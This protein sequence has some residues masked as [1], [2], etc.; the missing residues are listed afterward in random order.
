[1]KWHLR[2]LESTSAGLKSSS[3]R[4]AE[5]D[6]SYSSLEFG[7]N[8]ANFGTISSRSQQS[9][10]LDN[11]RRLSNKH[12]QPVQKKYSILIC[13]DFAFPKF[14]GVE[15]HGYQ[16]GQC[17]IERGHKVCFITNKF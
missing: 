8:L 13:T 16:L 10:Q 12:G 6:D 14:G 3:N 4:G 1:M 17:L 15:T 5:Y 2:E 9:S 11:S 7:Q